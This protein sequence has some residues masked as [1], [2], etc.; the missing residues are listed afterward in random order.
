MLK[1]NR[2][3]SPK[4][5]VAIMA[6]GAGTRFWTASTRDRPKQ[7]LRL[8]GERTMLQQSFDRARALTSL[9]RIFVVTNAAFMAL[10]REQL[11]ELSADNVVGEPER[12]DTAAAAVLS[13]LLADKC[14][15]DSVVAIL[16][17]DQLI[18]PIDAFVS[19][20][21]T[22]VES[23]AVDDAL[24]TI[25]VRPTFAATGYGY[26]ALGTTSA[27]DVFVVDKF[28][29]KPDAARAAE[30][31][32]SGKYVWNS[33]M[34]VWRTKTALEQMRAHLP[35]HVDA[36]SAAVSGTASLAEAFAAVPKISIDYGL[37]EK[38]PRVRC[39][40]A[41]FSWSDVGSF[42]SLADHVAHDDAGNS[43]A[44][45]R[46]VALDARGNVAFSEDPAELV[47]LVGVD[48]LIVVRSGKR[49][50]VAHKSRAEEI[51]KLVEKLPIEDG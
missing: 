32:K 22:A 9:D 26:L 6:G 31:L 1:R 19:C 8:I 48:D 23:A 12:K 33:G 25:G 27:K 16:T 14:A 51:K 3:S 11:P 35:K 34:F 30:Y 18:A 45:A 10:V 42:P 46:V 17:S 2:W 28:V 44:G 39:V 38:A 43:I 7:F 24:Y 40:A 13:T 50:L 4:L 29:E 37:M 20:M 36:L 5:V 41:T 15:G 21:R 47:A 49:T